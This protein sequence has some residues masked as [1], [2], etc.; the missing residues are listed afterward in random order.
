MSILSPF[1]PP[2][3][4]P[5]ETKNMI[6]IVGLTLRDYIA[7]HMKGAWPFINPEVHSYEEMV[8][9]YL[10]GARMQYAIA[11]AMLKAREEKR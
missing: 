10:D 8:E 5:T 2:T 1:G 9:H 4:D 6:G 7:C 3:P 11:D